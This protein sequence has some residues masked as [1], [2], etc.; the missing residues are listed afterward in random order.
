[1]KRIA[2]VAARVIVAAP[3]SGETAMTTIRQTG[4]RLVIALAALAVLVVGATAATAAPASLRAL[5]L[6][7]PS[8]GAQVTVTAAGGGTFTADP[9]RALLRVTP[10]GG[11]ASQVLAWCVDPA[12]VIAEGTDYPVD[13]QNASDTPAL[14]GPGFSQAGWLIAASDR[15][16]AD[17]ADPGL[18]AAAIQVAVWQLT[19]SVSGSYAV[20]S[21]TTLNARVAQIRAA[22]VGR[23][24][25]TEL[26]VSAPTAPVVAGSPVTVSVTG[27][28]GAVVDLAVTSGAA[29]LSARQVTIGPSGATVVTATPSA[30]GA[31]TIGASAQGGMLHRVV[32]LAGRPAPQSMAYVT[33]APLTA[34]AGITVLAPAVV[35]PLPVVV[36]AAIAQVPA[37]A[38]LG[39][40]KTAPATV[41]PGRVIGYRLTVTNVSAT[42]ARAVVVRDPVPLGTYVTRL[43]GTARLRAGAVEW[44]LGDLAPGARVTLVLRLRTDRLARGTVLNRATAAAANAALVRARATTR[45]VTAP[46]RTAPAVV[47]PAVVAP[48]VTG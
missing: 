32:R 35:T 39:L 48:A 3:I 21:D 25:V 37:A 30:A 47:A 40:A 2:A 42:V 36:P 28:P 13:L 18:E 10:A 20:T 46:R 27:T 14:A 31:V 41:R 1:M 33:A 45:M 38:T 12:R 6:E 19:G 16:I 17:A 23:A 9:G 5:D 8:L 29:T 15:M 34:S 43:P 11:P 44:R 4:A 22:A 24:L 7:S 26:A